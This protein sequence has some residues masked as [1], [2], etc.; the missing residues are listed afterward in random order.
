[1]LDDAVVLVVRIGPVVKIP[2]LPPVYEPATLISCPMPTPPVTT[3]APFVCVVEA[4]AFVVEMVP[5]VRIYAP[6]FMAPLTPI[7]PVT[8]KAPVVKEKKMKLN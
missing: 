4:V 1:V 7:P 3:S 2:P 5:L 8:T 6:P